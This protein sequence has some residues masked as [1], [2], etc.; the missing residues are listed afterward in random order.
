MASKQHRGFTLIELLITI[1]IIA[2]ISA[3]V[4][5][6][7]FSGDAFS[8]YTYRTNVL[9]KLQLIR[10]MAMQQTSPR[11]NQCHRVLITTTKM[12]VPDNCNIDPPTFNDSSTY[13]AEQ[14]A[15]NRKTL[16]EV[17]EKDNVTFSTNATDNTFSFDSMGK[18]QAG[19][20]PCII[21][22]ASADDT[23]QIRIESEG[24]IHAL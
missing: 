21:T 10:N 3:S 17:A 11:A 19:C 1:V 15:Q 24:Y 23:L 8:A 20:S 12:G 4:L 2:I 6:R 16:V 18:P 22:I 13:T 5:P 9:A 7:M 14:Q